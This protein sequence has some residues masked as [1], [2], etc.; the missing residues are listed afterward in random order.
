MASGMHHNFASAA[1]AEEEIGDHPEKVPA[2][3]QRSPGRPAPTG[4]G[5]RFSRQSPPQSTPLLQPGAESLLR[6]PS[7]PM[8]FPK[9]SLPGSS[10]YNSPS[11]TGSGTSFPMYSSPSLRLPTNLIVTENEGATFTIRGEL[12][13]PGQGIFKVDIQ[14]KAQIVATLQV[15]QDDIGSG[16]LFVLLPKSPIA[17]LDTQKS[18]AAFGAARQVAIF[19]ASDEYFDVTDT[20]AAIVKLDGNNFI[21]TRGHDC[22]LQVKAEGFRGPERL[23]KVEDQHGHVLARILNDPGSYHSV[24]VLRG[25]DAGLILMATVACFK[26]M[27]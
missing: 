14:K 27:G 25:C 7:K 2:T 5:T 8:E 1:L 10:A 21:M 26:L 12:N 13:H 20:P 23:T 11:L 17:F 18:G 16:I 22:L 4:T 6:S 15:S 19:G 3:Y 9:P 24:H